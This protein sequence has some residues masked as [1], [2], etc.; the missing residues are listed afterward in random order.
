[1]ELSTP[2]SK[3]AAGHGQPLGEDGED[4]QR[5]LLFY[6]LGTVV[7][8]S[9]LLALALGILVCRKRRAKREI[10]EKKPQNAADSYTWVPERAEGREN[11]YR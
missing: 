1:M 11:Q 6:I 8:I 3:A 7:A 9:L 4:G 2:L 5:L 10:K